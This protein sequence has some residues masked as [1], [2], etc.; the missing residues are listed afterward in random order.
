MPADN[1][2][3]EVFPDGTANGMVKVIMSDEA[4]VAINGVSASGQF[5]FGHLFLQR[6]NKYE[7]SY[8]HLKMCQS[9]Y[10]F[11]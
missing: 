1:N 9:N 3:G 6:L 8:T 5:N 7:Y 2:W 4:D 11:F 10:Y